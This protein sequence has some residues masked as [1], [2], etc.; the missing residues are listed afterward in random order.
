MARGPYSLT[1]DCYRSKFREGR[2][3]MIHAYNAM[4]GSGKAVSVT[5]MALALTGAGV[6]AAYV[7]MELDEPSEFEEEEEPG[8]AFG[9]AIALPAA[10][11]EA[12]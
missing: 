6:A 4:R 2:E 9:G 8:P 11:K 10:D 5:L 12:G 7:R 3:K 1:E